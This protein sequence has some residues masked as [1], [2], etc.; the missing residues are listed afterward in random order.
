M[1]QAAGPPEKPTWNTSFLFQGQ[2]VAA[3]FPADTALAIEYYPATATESGPPQLRTLSLTPHR[4]C[5]EVPGSALSPSP[6]W[7]APGPLMPLGH[8]VLPLSGGVLRELRAQGSAVH[9]DGLSVQGMELQATSWGSPTVGLCLQ[10]LASERPT[11]FLTPLGSDAHPSLGLTTTSRLKR[12]E[13]P[14]AGPG[15]PF[16]CQDSGCAARRK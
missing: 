1:S 3:L 6:A 15:H 8:S 4:L 11:E 9:V 16:D 14:H 13:E 5:P 7:D 2:A 10:L 12:G